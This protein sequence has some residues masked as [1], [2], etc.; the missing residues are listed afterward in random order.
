M[1]DR[2]TE[3]RTYILADTVIAALVGTRMY[4]QVLP[5]NPTYPAI[6]YTLIGGAGSVVT[7]D[8]PAGLE[9]VSL[10][11]DCW[12]QTQLTAAALA[13]RVRT[14]INGYTGGAFQGI[15]LARKRDGYDNDAMAYRRSA[16]F[17]IWNEESA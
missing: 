8:G 2:F 16:D 3:L 12:A 6:T 10:Q 13:E 5:Q 7:H 4:P 17:S 9:N 11:I 15:F 14:R 1:A